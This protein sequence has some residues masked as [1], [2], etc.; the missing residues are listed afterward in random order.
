MKTIVLITTGQPSVNPRIVKEADA[1]HGAG[2]RVI[3]LY[4]FWI[5]WAHEADK[6]LL[7][8][9]KWSYQL[10]G[11]SPKQNRLTYYFTKLRYKVNNALSDQGY[12]RRLVAERAQARSFDELLQAAK[13]IQADAFI[14]HNLGALPIAVRAARYRNALAGF[15]FE[16]YHRE[17][18]EGEKTT[19]KDRIVY[20]EE[21]YVPHLYYTSTSSPLITEKVK[22]NFPAAKGPVFSLLN[23]FPLSART[24]ETIVNDVEGCLHLFWFSQTVG[25]NRGLEAVVVALKELDNKSIHLTLAGRYDATMMLFIEEHCAKI[26]ETFHF[27]GI[28]APESLPAF[29]ARFDVGLA[30]EITT[31]LNRNICLTNKIFTYLLAGNCI[32]ASDTEAQKN[33]MDTYPGIGLLY[34]SDNVRDIAEKIKFLYDNKEF[35]RRCKEAAFTLA[36]TELNWENESKKLL[37]N[38]SLLSAASN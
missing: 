23:C 2:Y 13:S 36:S 32:L 9:V 16:D 1:L 29:S 33:F 34:E 8:N 28:I 15:D 6:R 5:S 17:E 4:C 26:K 38:L 35:L 18:N 30:T 37:S 31:P 25:K 10:V 27:P 24:K 11:G 22:V 21:K 7:A 14:G 19:V 3:V 12:S 20:L